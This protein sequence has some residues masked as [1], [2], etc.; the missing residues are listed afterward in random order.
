MFF[1]VLAS[2]SFASSARFSR[3]TESLVTTT[4]GALHAAA[5]A[6]MTTMSAVITLATIRVDVDRMMHFL[7]SQGRPPEPWDAGGSKPPLRLHRRTIGPAIRLQPYNP[8]L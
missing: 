5:Q 3:E 7:L 1:G 6:M 2:S 8:R 4:C